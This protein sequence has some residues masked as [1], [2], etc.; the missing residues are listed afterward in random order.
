MT[1]VKVC[2]ENIFAAICF[3]HTGAN[4][5]VGQLAI[6]KEFSVTS[7][8]QLYAIEQSIIT[9]KLE[10]FDFFSVTRAPPALLMS[11]SF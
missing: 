9:V 4:I 10:K 7:I 2:K 6:L 11:I 8:K 5:S 1:N 3:I